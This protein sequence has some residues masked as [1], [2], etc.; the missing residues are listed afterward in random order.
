MTSLELVTAMLNT[1]TAREA[2]EASTLVNA[3]AT[4][5]DDDRPAFAD[6]ASHA[7]E[8]LILTRDRIAGLTTLVAAMTPAPEGAP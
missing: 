4:A 8:N 7:A 6:A 3:L 1:A 5:S 2:L